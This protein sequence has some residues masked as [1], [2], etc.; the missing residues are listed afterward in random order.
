MRNIVLR[1][2]LGLL[3]TLVLSGKVFGEEIF[4]IG[5]LKSVKLY[6]PSQELVRDLPSGLQEIVISNSC[7]SAEVEY[8]LKDNELIVLSMELGE[9]CKSPFGAYPR[10]HLIVYEENN[11]LLEYYPIDQ[12]SDGREFVTPGMWFELAKNQWTPLMQPLV[13]DELVSSSDSEYYAK[14]VSLGLYEIR[15]SIVYQKQGVFLEN[16]PQLVAH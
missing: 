1:F 13:I 4:T 7:G 11:V 9:W 16:V 8:L 3:A 2:I 15:G 6:P 5:I 10:R 12:D 14:Q